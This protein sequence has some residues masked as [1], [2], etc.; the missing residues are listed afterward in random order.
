[1]KSQAVS[2]H[3]LIKKK[4]ISLP[5]NRHKTQVRSKHVDSTKDDMHLLGQLYISLQVREGHAD[6]LFEVEY[7]DAPPS[8]SKNGKLR[9]RQTSDLVYCLQTD[10]PSD[11]GEADVKLID[12]AN[13]V[14]ALSIK[15]F[16]DYAE[17]KMI[18]FIKWHLI[19]AR[20][21]DVIWD[22]YLSD[23]LKATTTESRGAGVQQRLLNDG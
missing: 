16:H 14:H 2:F 17:N 21:D 13:M 22:R 1:M 10:S 9:S 8:L 4:K 20:L 12:G 15:T 7:L 19:T 18:P 3:E 6:S 11:Y 23:S 5:S